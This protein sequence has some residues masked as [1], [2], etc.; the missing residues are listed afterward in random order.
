MERVVESN[1]EADE[2]RPSK[3]RRS[4]TIFVAMLS[5]VLKNVQQTLRFARRTGLANETAE[6]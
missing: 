5:A 6:F 4:T 3:K 2:M 1:V